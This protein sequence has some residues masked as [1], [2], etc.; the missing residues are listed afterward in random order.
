MPS[1]ARQKKFEIK[2]NKHTF[3]FSNHSQIFSLCLNFSL[4]HRK[5]FSLCLKIFPCVKAK[6]PVFSLSGKSKNQIPSF[7]CALATLLVLPLLNNACRPTGN[8]QHFFI[9][10]LC[11]SNIKNGAKCSLRYLSGKSSNEILCAVPD[12]WEFEVVDDDGRPGEGGRS[13]ADGGAAL[14]GVER[15]V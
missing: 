2:K 8:F 14:L 4:C 9:T 11:S 12:G 13:S 1:E 7:P 3:Y 10:F 6:F 15:V 5:I